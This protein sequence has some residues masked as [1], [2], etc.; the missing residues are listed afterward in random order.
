[1]TD[2]ELDILTNIIGGV[3]SG[4]QV[5]GERKYDAYAAPYQ[6]SPNE[7]TVTLGW[8]QF[9]GNNARKLCQ[10]IFNKD[11]TMFRKYDN[12][13][14]EN[15]LKQDWVEIKWKPTL[16]EKNSLI[17]IITTSVGK[18]TQDEL[19]KEDM[20]TFIKD[21]EAFGISDVGAQMMYCEIRHLGGKLPAER[22]FKRASKPYTSDT[23]YSS[24][25]LDQNDMSNNNQVGDKIYQ[26]RHQKCVEWIHAYIYNDKGSDKVSISNTIIQNVINDAVNFA[27]S[28]ANDNIHG[29]S[30][31]V[32]SLYNTISPTSFDCS[33]LVCTAYYYAFIKNGLVS[34]ANYLK[35][36]CSYTGNME[37]M[38]NCGF[39]VVAINQTGH[40]QMKKGDIELNIKYHT[41]MAIDGDNIVHARSSEGTNNTI[42]DSGNEIRVQPWYLYSKGWDQRLRFTGKGIA[43]TSSS[44]FASTSTSTSSSSTGTNTAS[45]TTNN[46][47]TSSSN[48]ISNLNKTTKFTGITI[49]ELN[50]RTWAGKNY[51]TV[52]FSPLKKGTVINIC[53]TVKDVN[54]NDW[55]YIS[56]NGK[57]GFVISD[58]V[59]N[60]NTINTSY[61]KTKFIK[62]IQTS[63]NI[64][65]DGIAGQQTLNAVPLLSKT[66]NNNHIIV[67]YL[68]KYLN[69][70][71]YNVGDVDQ[72]FG[73]KTESQIKLLQIKYKIESDGIV[74]P[75]TWRVILC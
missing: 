46:N 1:M 32:R 25:L 10:T 22:I 42:D 74:G 73:N 17:N 45:S 18:E 23:V 58:Y 56:Y 4:G 72:I 3:E 62:D 37:K 24:L 68:Q 49:D 64:V 67:K 7:V 41:A 65:V 39:E 34:Q 2:K 53:D 59:S 15:R 29:Y 52:S 48:I 8:C 43:S 71:G 5:Y 69:N 33:S 40:S 27:V 63:L 12:A 16:S 14:I 36:N 57:T 21:A 38:I 19:F 44:N 51:K 66:I 54:G 31:A 70:I 35:A 26:S 11:S 30:Q 60:Q 47:F 55:Y 13:K 6:N 61:S 28:I 20:K 50:V 75:Q 9:Y